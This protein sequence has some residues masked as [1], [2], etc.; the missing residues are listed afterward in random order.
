MELQIAGLSLLANPDLSEPHH[1]SVALACHAL[2][3]QLWGWFAAVNCHPR[4]AFSFSFSSGGVHFWYSRDARL[5][6]LQGCVGIP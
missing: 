6:W 2:D 1:H 3:L 4:I 5:C